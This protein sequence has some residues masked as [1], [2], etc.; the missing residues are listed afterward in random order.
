MGSKGGSSQTTQ[1]SQS[2]SPPPQVMADYQALVNRATDQA[3]TPYT[4]YPGE[5]VAPI[6][7]QTTQGLGGINSY[8]NSAQPFYSAAATGTVNAAS[9]ISAQPFS[10]G[11][12]DQYQNPYT[13]DVVNSTEQQF[14]NQNEQQAQFLNSQN[15]SS[16]AFGGDRAGISQAVLA[17]QQ[18]TAQAPVIAGLYNQAYNQALSEFNTQQGVGLQTQAFN[19]QQLGQMANQLS[20]IG[21][22][23][24]GAGLQGAMAQIQGGEIPQQEQQSIDTALY[25]QYMQQQSYPYQTTGWLGNIIEGTGSLSGGTSGG[26][27]TTTSQSGSPIS[28]GVGSALSGLGILGSFLSDREAKEDI[29]PIGKT[30]DGQTIYRFRY[31]GDPRTQ[32]GLI[33]QETEKKHPEAVHRSGMRSVNY[34]DATRDAADRGH[35]AL[36]GAARFGGRR[37]LATGGNGAGV[38]AIG[39]FD[40]PLIN[41]NLNPLAGYAN[42]EYDA[43]TANSTDPQVGIDLSVPTAIGS[44]P[45]LPNNGF[46]AP[47]IDW[48]RP[49]NDFQTAGAEASLQGLI[50]RPGIETPTTETSSPAATVPSSPMLNPDA[51]VLFGLSQPKQQVTQ[52]YAPDPIDHGSAAGASGAGAGAG[53]WR[54]GPIAR[55][56]RAAGGQLG[57]SGMGAALAQPP[58]GAMVN[59]AGQGEFGNL[60]GPGSARQTFA[61]GGAP[62]DPTIGTDPFS[63]VV[64]WVPQVQLGVPGHGPPQPSGG[65]GGANPGK[66][67]SAAQEQGGGLGGLDKLVS[68]LKSKLGGGSGTSGGTPS[69]GQA[70]PTTT[71]TTAVN[72]PTGLGLT[73]ADMSAMPDFSGQA[74]Q[75]ALNLSDSD[76]AGLSDSDITGGGADA[77]GGGDFSDTPDLS[78]SDFSGLTDAD[79]GFRRG[80][81]IN[82]KKRGHFDAGGDVDQAIDPDL[83]AQAPT[84]PD[85][86]PPAISNATA[87]PLPA[88]ASPAALSPAGGPY[89]DVKGQRFAT[90]GD[91]KIVGP[92]N[93]AQPATRQAAAQPSGSPGLTNLDNAIATGKMPAAP[94]AGPG[95][96]A[97]GGAAAPAAGAAPSDTRSLF[98]NNLRKLGLNPQQALGALYGLGGESGSGLDPTAY[99]PKD[100]GGALGI[101]QWV[102]PRRAGLEQMASQMGLSPTDPR[103][104]AAYMT[105]ELTGQAGGNNYS[106]VLAQLKN[107]PDAATAT[108]IWTGA[109]ENPRVNNWGARYARGQQAMGTIDAQGNFVPGK[110]SYGSM[111]GGLTGQM[112]QGAGGEQNGQQQ[113]VAQNVMSYSPDGSGKPY[114]NQ[115]DL[116]NPWSNNRELFHAMMYAGF[117][118][119]G[120]ESRNPWVNIGRGAMAGAD[121]MQKQTGLD[122]DWVKTQA[123]INH[124][125]AEDRRGDADVALRTQQ[126]NIEMQKMRLAMD[127]AKRS[128]DLDNEEIGGGAPAATAQPEQPAAAPAA[129][130]ATTSGIGAPGEGTG[131]PII[132]TGGGMGYPSMGI[133]PPAAAGT[134]AG[135][136][137]GG[138]V[139]LS[140]GKSMPVTTDASIPPAGAP[141]M[142]AGA[143]GAAP[144]VQPAQQQ[145][146][147][148]SGPPNA[149]Q[150]ATA[151]PQGGD[152]AAFNAE[153]QRQQ[154]I[155]MQRARIADARTAL[156]PQAGQEA[157]RLR[158]QARDLPKQEQMY[159][160]GHGVMTNP[161]IVASKAAIAGGE[162]AAKLGAQSSPQAL[163]GQEG[164]ARAKATGEQEGKP[165][166]DQEGHAYLPGTPEYDR[167]TQ[168]G[169]PY[170][171]AEPPEAKSM[172]ANFEAFQKDEQNFGKTYQANREML[173]NLAGIYQNYRSGRA[174]EAIAD[175]TGY[176][177]QFHLSGVLPKGWQNSTAGF[178]S[179]MKEAVKNSFQVLQDSGAQRAPRT[180]LQE[181]MLT[182]PRPEAAPAAVWNM[183]THGL[184]TLDWSKDMYQSVGSNYNVNKALND[185]NNSKNFEDYLNSARK[186]IPLSKGTTPEA[187]KIVTGGKNLERD[188]K[189][190]RV[191]DKV[192][193][194]H[195]D[196]AGNV[197]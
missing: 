127:A 168:S 109:Y 53:A 17:N 143:R 145:Q 66:S 8:A 144:A 11:A 7:N 61:S 30:F 100:P 190:G 182:S 196:A 16:G 79:L 84:A 197:E 88:G 1:S 93:A 44:P 173:T 161:A 26:T 9:P 92:A 183:I 137:G 148:P 14:N 115:Q 25:N 116:S 5:L 13:N 86:P 152:A 120:G 186:E 142:P 194:A 71:P 73:T 162:E 191:R 118:M 188:A 112:P 52:P 85:Q 54:G 99:N 104:Q 57:Q 96:P 178:D 39:N 12:V 29:R 159:V 28:S 72:D 65:G 138:T 50:N 51:G 131:A 43:V 179:A 175:L 3:N 101:G 78:D 58:Q 135:V 180:G 164:I 108:R 123:E 124:M 24:Q 165:I 36:G 177:D 174:S 119:M 68:G 42:E 136:P 114:F 41:G 34:D 181:A 63:E 160:P 59:G 117:A 154:R 155:L 80:G 166:Y 149:P 18:Q 31:K 38:D 56:Y 132:T 192:T 10:A 105:A 48:Q 77:G 107:A 64:S 76:F 62:T 169:Q 74:D 139:A 150:Q 125:G 6:S 172:S 81:F 157:D 156:D 193:G 130:P 19:N 21:T 22:A 103:A 97:A 147:P 163:S 60:F 23:E 129:P 121:Y 67:G 151:G 94:A 37:H 189:T 146:T 27:S 87:T 32:I 91:G 89:V 170:F 35:F 98:F 140:P 106:G 133:K 83:A 113:Q 171:A 141:G 4:Q 167:L 33:A 15:I 69:P 2:S 40:S 49:G 128:Q 158:Q 46:T 176:L 70:S 45:P 102:G 110:G 134:P 95:Q 153:V 184:A 47:N 82:G 20:G 75:N 111:S 195:W 55:A 90:D 122:R 126:M 187:Y 185:F